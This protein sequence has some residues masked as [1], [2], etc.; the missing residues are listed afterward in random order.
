MDWQSQLITEQCT[1]RCFD[2]TV[3]EEESD[4]QSYVIKAVLNK[5]IENV[6]CSQGLV[7]D[8]DVMKK[9][10]NTIGESLVFFKNIIAV[11]E[12]EMEPSREILDQLMGL[13]SAEAHDPVE[14]IENIA[15]KGTND[16]VEEVDEVVENLAEEI[17]KE[18]E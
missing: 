3:F 7:L 18:G 12:E 5:M 4:A 10:T 13:Q 6:L 2:D 9:V 1:F 11:S 14:A 15:R 17:A 16:A 8:A